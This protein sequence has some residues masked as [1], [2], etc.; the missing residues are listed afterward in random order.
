VRGLAISLALAVAALALPPVAD[1][2]VTS[3][4]SSGALTVSS[5][6]DDAITIA[7][8]NN[9]V[10]VNSVE[11]SGPVLCASVTSVA[12]TGGP[13]ANIPIDLNNV[14]ANTFPF[15]SS[16]SVNAGD[17]NDTIIG[18]EFNDEIVGGN[19]QDTLV[20]SDGND[21]FT[22][23]DE[24]STELFNGGNG[25]DTITFGGTA[26]GIITSTPTSIDNL[27]GANSVLEIEGATFNAP[28]Q[29]NSFDLTNAP[30]P[31]I[32]NGNGSNDVFYSSAFNDT[33]NGGGQGIA[34]VFGAKTDSANIQISSGAGGAATMTGTTIGTDTM[35]NVE[36][37]QVLSPSVLGPSSVVANS[38]WDASTFVGPVDFEGGTGN[39]TL[40][41]GSAGD[42]LGAPGV[43][44]VGSLEEGDDTLVGNGGG[45]TLRG[46][47]GTDTARQTGVAAA[48]VGASSMNANGTDT[49]NSI[50]VVSLS[51]TGGP[52]TMAATA[53]GG[54]VI[55]EGFGAS[56]TLTGSGQDD[57]IS[58]GD[59]ADSLTGGGGID[60]L[61]E[62]AFAP[63]SATL[64]DTSLSGFG[65]APTDTLAGFERAILNGSP[66]ADSFDASA[67]TGP[68]TLAGGDGGDTLTGGAAADSLLGG[69]GADTLKAKDGGA[70]ALIDCGA[71]DD[72]AETDD[73]DPSPVGCETVNGVR[74]GPPDNP[75]DEPLDTTAPV[76]KVSIGRVN[77]RGRLALRLTC[78]ADEQSC[79]GNLVLRLAGRKRTRLG[80]AQFTVA[81]GKVVALKVKLTRKGRA[82]LRRKHR[83]R[84]VLTLTAT[85]AANNTQTQKKTIR[86]RR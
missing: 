16:A 11:M 75:P 39:D 62:T 61:R 4:F 78:P 23:A 17:G 7:C 40:M 41:G 33:F 74:L 54:R 26:N 59:G 8:L 56:D 43:N 15:V 5:N 77:R 52:D 25:T 29:E 48:T 47:P 6:A 85:D 19:G 70:D 66:G 27:N 38:T 57:E 73:T 46:G 71:D 2:T 13:Q 83:L 21:H 24:G 76:M 58:G 36:R 55:F 65:G 82:L 28:F 12:V 3:S 80:S 72:S 69:A 53:F 64:T 67:F 49:F 30:F 9:N 45:D 84:A 44:M 14:R 60:T 50:D 31:S 81:G 68:V 37:A 22:E 20:G 18:T 34:D 10:V 1:A 35:T 42:T 63:T 32:V 86:I 79:T 51:G